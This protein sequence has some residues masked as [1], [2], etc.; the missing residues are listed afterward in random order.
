MQHRESSD[1]KADGRPERES[2]EKNPESEWHQIIRRGFRLFHGEGWN[3]NFVIGVGVGLLFIFM[4]PFLSSPKGQIVA[5]WSGTMILVSVAFGLLYRA[6]DIPKPTADAK[7][8]RL[9]ADVLFSSTNNEV[10]ARFDVCDAGPLFVWEG[11]PGEP[12][13]EIF[14]ASTLT[15]ARVDG[16]IAV[17]TTIK[18]REGKL[19]AEIVANEW[20][21]RPSKLWDKNF[22]HDS[23]EVRDESGDVVLQ[24]TA[25]LDFVRIRGKWRDQGGKF[26]E[27][28]ESPDKTGTDMRFSEDRA[29]PIAPLFRYPSETHFGELARTDWRPNPNPNRWKLPVKTTILIRDPRTSP[30][31]LSGER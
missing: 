14:G 22:N 2:K 5:G 24:V 31:N 28:T 4:T 26:M 19:V 17:S 11:P 7:T 13:F 25:A 18:D 6:A 20:Q 16:A 30:A 15:V 9:K 21:V 27:M 23:L 8:G 3:P 1:Q 29:I 10:P 12:F